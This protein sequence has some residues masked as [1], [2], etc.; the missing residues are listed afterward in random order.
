MSD[1]RTPLRG[2]SASGS[3]AAAYLRLSYTAVGNQLPRTRDQ[4]WRESIMARQVGQNW[5]RTFSICTV[6]SAVSPRPSRTSA[7]GRPPQVAR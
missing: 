4:A 1:V 6:R 5:P 7:A 3:S 2:S